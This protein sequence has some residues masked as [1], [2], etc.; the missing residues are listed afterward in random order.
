MHFLPF[1]D[2]ASVL[3]AIAQPYFNT[4]AFYDCNITNHLKLDTNYHKSY[5][6]IP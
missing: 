6:A 4:T 3:L 2:I 1:R 5:I